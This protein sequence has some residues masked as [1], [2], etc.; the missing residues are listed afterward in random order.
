MPEARFCPTIVIDGVFFQLN[1]TGISRVWYSILKEWNSKS[2]LALNVVVLDRENTA[3]RFENIKYR[4]L[5]AYSYNE[6]GLDSQ[7]L[8]AA[9]DE[10]KAD[11]FISTYY[12]TPITTPSVFMA[13]DMV[14]EVIEAN[15]K[16]PMWREKH[17]GIRHA[18]QYLA[19]SQN[20]A[21]DLIRFFP[22]ILSESVNVAHC[23]IDQELFFPSSA[24]K[25]INCA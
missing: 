8:Q 13:Y 19:I 20:T 7:I 11:L 1:N 21:D 10:A 17:L 9:C 16:E 23:G 6:T 15:L 5:P 18:C 12:T 3:P 24:E 2:N 22:E 4:D 14:P 25:I